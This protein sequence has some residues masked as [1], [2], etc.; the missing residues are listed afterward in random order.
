MHATYA[1]SQWQP[2]RGLLPGP[3]IV[4]ALATA[5]VLT[6]FS[7]SLYYRDNKLV[8]LALGAVCGLVCVA[9]FLLEEKELFDVIKQRLGF[10]AEKEK[11]HAE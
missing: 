11:D 6:N 9:V 2:L 10:G 8:H 5:F 1:G 3:L 4:T 7:E